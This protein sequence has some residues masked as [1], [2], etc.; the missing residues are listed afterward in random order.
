MRVLI[1]VLVLCNL[2][3]FA[4]T[5]GYFGVAENPDAQRLQQQVHPERIKLVAQEPGAT[6]VPAPAPSAEVKT[7]KPQELPPPRCLVW[8]GL[9][10]SES[11]TLATRLGKR[12]P[13]LKLKQIAPAP[14]GTWWVFVPPLGSRK[15]AEA[16]VSTMEEKGLSDILA[17]QDGPSRN[18][19]SLGIFSSEEG[20]YQRLKEVQGKGFDTAR[21]VPRRKESAYALEVR[22][23]D[24][25]LG[26]ARKVSAAL[27]KDS[28]P[29]VCK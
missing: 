23:S 10:Q 13:S 7:T 6:P 28:R 2:L 18:A 25:D 15:E 14:T 27:V 3:F 26:E 29:Q 9:Q 1:F 17:M 8:N 12:Y 11:D 24:P 19:V 22:G 4:F 20:A 5:Q 21:L 16:L